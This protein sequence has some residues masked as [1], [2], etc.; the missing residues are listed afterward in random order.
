MK[1]VAVELE[2]RGYQVARNLSLA[3]YTTMR[4][5][6]T[7]ELVVYPRSAEELAAVLGLLEGMEVPWTV[8]GG[9]SNVIIG[10]ELDGVV[11]ST[12]RLK[13]VR[14]LDGARLEAE[15]GAVLGQALNLAL[16]GDL[17]GLEFAA[18]IPGSVGGGVVMNAGA[19]GRELKDVIECVWVWHGGR[20]VV[21]TADEIGFEYRKAHLPPGSVVTRARLRLTRGDGARG[22]AVVRE[23]LKRRAA[24]QP[25]EKANS[26]CVFKN[27]PDIPAGMLLEQLGFKG[28]RRGG[29]AFSTVHANFIINLGGATFGDVVALIRE[30]RR[31]AYE[32]RGIVLETE[33]KLL[34]AGGVEVS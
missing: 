27:P 2:K 23:L 31:I 11:V 30:A 32:K 16:A 28:V 21:L 3:R 24:T 22:R 26:G 4:V 19:N 15:A 29:A 14:V 6:C 1:S 20:E 5:G 7:S 10:P 17:R 8:L 9:G 13:R 25:V 18:G 33:V 12:K 34:G